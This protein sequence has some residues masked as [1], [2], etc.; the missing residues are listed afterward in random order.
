MFYFLVLIYFYFFQLG[1]LFDFV[2]C[3]PFFSLFFP[4]LVIGG[5]LKTFSGCCLGISKEFLSPKQYGSG[6]EC[7]R[8]NEEFVRHTGT[9]VVELGVGIGQCGESCR[10]KKGERNVEERR[11]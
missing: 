5:F 3:N 11:G 1:N 9:Y 6:E 8:D 4:A 10:R 7:W 2:S